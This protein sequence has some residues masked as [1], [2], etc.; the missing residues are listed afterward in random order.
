MVPIWSTVKVP[1]VS[2]E[3]VVNLLEVSGVANAQSANPDQV[4]DN[5]LID[6]LAGQ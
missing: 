6:S 4:F 5:S 1:R 2:R 3:G